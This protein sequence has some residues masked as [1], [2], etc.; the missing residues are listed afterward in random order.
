MPAPKLALEERV[1]RDDGAAPA[2]ENARVADPQDFNGESHV[3]DDRALEIIRMVF[4]QLN[5]ERGNGEKKGMLT[6]CLP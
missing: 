5:V 2:H 6:A 3:Q 1:D 4:G